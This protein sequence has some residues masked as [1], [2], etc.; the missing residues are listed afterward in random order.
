MVFFLLL[1]LMDF[2]APNKT[3]LVIIQAPILCAEER[4]RVAQK[5]RISHE[6]LRSPSTLDPK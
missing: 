5:A 6:P 2:R 4:H 1:L 3:V